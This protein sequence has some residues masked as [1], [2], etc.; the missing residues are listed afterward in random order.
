MKSLN[1]PAFSWPLILYNLD[2]SYS[3]IYVVVVNIC[4]SAILNIDINVC[5]IK[6]F[7]SQMRI[8]QTARVSIV[9]ITNYIH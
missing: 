2:L 6:L 4:A 9:D 5:I 3:F 8:V 7:K 1:N